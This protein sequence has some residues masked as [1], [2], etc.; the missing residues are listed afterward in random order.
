[1][2]WQSLDLIKRGIAGPSDMHCLACCVN[3]CA[4]LH[5][6][7][8]GKDYRDVV[9]AGLDALRRIMSRPKPIGDGEGLTALA[10]MLELYD[11]QVKCVTQ[12]EFVDA[13]LYVEKAVGGR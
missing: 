2:G 11:E 3:V 9:L 12:R 10:T 1:M 4:V 8:H 7:G 13:L 6:R 5:E